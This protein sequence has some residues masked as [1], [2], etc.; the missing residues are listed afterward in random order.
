MVKNQN[1]N[2]NKNIAAA[3]LKGNPYRVRIA[4]AVLMLFIAFI[5]IRLINIPLERDEG[6]YA[7]MGQLILQGVPPYEIAY[8]MK[9]PGT[10]Y[11]YAFFMSIFGQTTTG[12][13]AGLLLMNLSSILLIFLLVKKLL[14]DYAAIVS[15]SA[16]AFLSVGM[17]ILGFAG[18]ATHFVIVPA[19]AGAI[20][21]YQAVK[22]NKLL[23]YFLAGMLL[24][25][26]PIMKQQG[27]LFCAFGTIVMLGNFYFQRQD[28][29][30][31]QAKRFLFFALGG[32]LP[33]AL[34]FLFLKLAGVFDQF[35]FW[36]IVYARSYETAV[37]LKDALLL[38]KASFFH[39][40]S[41][42]I[43]IWIFAG[44]GAVAIFL[45]PKLKKNFKSFFIISFF[46]FSFLSVCPGFYFRQHYFVTLLPALAILFGVFISFL[47]EV[48]LNNNKCRIAKFASYALFLIPIIIGTA[49]QKDYL[50]K[51]NPDAICEKAYGGNPFTQSVPIAAYV[52]ANSRERDKIAVLGSEPQICFY[53]NRRSATGYIYTYGLMEIHEH[54][55]K[56]QKEMVREIE[57]G[58]PRFLIWVNVPTSWLAQSGSEKY[59]F[60]WINPYLQKNSYMIAGVA[61]MYANTT[62][63]KWDDEARNYKTGSNSFILIF[64]KSDG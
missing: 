25:F 21:L 4:L 44:F 47:Y 54:S 28:T 45:H 58:N 31:V 9:F 14:D 2:Q 18:H 15:A 63:Y 20:F 55:L 16:F 36:T 8:N 24:S 30:R 53:A 11:M 41:D 60:N 13:H 32:I 48:S 49:A 7:Y 17:N 1:K 38:F 23:H 40:A 19:L 51:M 64:K 27:I 39:L 29:L 62:I 35:W 59:I 12:V 52:K 6:E 22:G 37:G 43:L 34:L 57:K 3:H 26:A 56:M 42:F 61:D 10:Y 33:V 5:R 46:V 50:F